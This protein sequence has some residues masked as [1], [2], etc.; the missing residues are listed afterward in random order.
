MDARF[1]MLMECM[2]V[3]LGDCTVSKFLKYM[4]QLDCSGDRVRI[5]GLKYRE[6]LYVWELRGFQDTV[7]CKDL[8]CTFFGGPPIC[9]RWYSGTLLTLLI[10]RF[11]TSAFVKEDGKAES[12]VQES[13]P[14]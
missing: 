6:D 8:P 1:T 3:T 11:F 13:V 12:I 10:D 9:M 7:L 2:Q 4:K 14:F 5:K